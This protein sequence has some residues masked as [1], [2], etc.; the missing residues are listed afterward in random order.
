MTDYELINITLDEIRRSSTVI[1][2]V[3]HES[4]IRSIYSSEKEVYDGMH[5]RGKTALGCIRQKLRDVL[6]EISEYRNNEGMLDEDEIEFTK[7]AYDL[8]YKND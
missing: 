3:S 7:G 2:Q 4:A 5:T 1:E 8:I 6:D